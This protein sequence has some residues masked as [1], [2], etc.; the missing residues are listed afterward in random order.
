MSPLL[1]A[2]L[3]AS[4]LGGFSL[5]CYTVVLVVSAVLVNSV[6]EARPCVSVARAHS[7]QVWQWKG[8]ESRLH[9]LRLRLP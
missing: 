8:G 5:H 2:V 1:R 6:S 3:E 4:N 9:S 7:T